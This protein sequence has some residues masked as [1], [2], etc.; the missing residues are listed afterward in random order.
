MT[1]W[2]YGQRIQEY[3][4][5]VPDH[6]RSLK[7]WYAQMDMW[8]VVID[9]SYAQFK[10]TGLG[11]LERNFGYN[12]LKSIADS[13]PFLLVSLLIP[14]FQNHGHWGKDSYVL[15]LQGCHPGQPHITS[16]LSHLDHPNSLLTGTL[17]LFLKLSL[18]L[19]TNTLLCF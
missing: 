8:K 13:K 7:E 17:V 16:L 4:N 19:L 12:S 14:K 9:S 18:R 2:Y 3:W 11:H 6:M 15:P 1:R 5:P 10:L